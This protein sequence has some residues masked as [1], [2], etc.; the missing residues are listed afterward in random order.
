MEWTKYIKL[1]EGAVSVNTLK[2]I[3]LL[4]TQGESFGQ[5]FL[6]G[7]QKY[8]IY[9]QMLPL[10]SNSDLIA[11]LPDIKES[12]VPLA[13]MFEFTDT[14]LPGFVYAW[15]RMNN[16]KIPL[17]QYN[18]KDLLIIRE[19]LLY[20]GY[21][22]SI[23][24]LEDNIVS[25]IE[26]YKELDLEESTLAEKMFNQKLKQFLNLESKL[27]DDMET[28]GW[29]LKSLSKKINISDELSEYIELKFTADINTKWFVNKLREHQ[30]LDELRM[31]IA[32][33]LYD[34]LIRRI[35][36]AGGEFYKMDQYEN[37]VTLGKILNRKVLPFDEYKNE[38]D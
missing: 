38:L 18:L 32:N 14:N 27:D 36:R 23:K 30:P 3:N 17:S 16:F 19:W 31:K 8:L 2:A 25:K 15:I 37:L 22:E 1:K 13:T 21:S 35:K 9:G 34:K 10:I 28:A 29:H 24:Y 6:I 5:S 11:N 20:F 33:Y 4:L 26:D 12:D 7:V